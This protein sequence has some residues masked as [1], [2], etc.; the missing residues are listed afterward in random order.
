[1]TAE[2]PSLAADAGRGV[3][4]YL[5]LLVVFRLAGR[6]SLA[7]LTT[8]DLVVVF[9]ISA[10]ARPL[11]QRPDAGVASGVVLVTVLVAMHWVLAWAKTRWQPLARLLDGRPT[12]LWNRGAAM[13]AAMRREKVDDEDILHAARS[14][15]GLSALDQVERAYLE[16]DG[17]ISVIPKR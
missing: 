7:E 5:F 6:R 8:F 14:R 15:H 12:L 3:L 13:R 9:L 2:I 10:A 16:V 1:M 4:A 17:T 11:L